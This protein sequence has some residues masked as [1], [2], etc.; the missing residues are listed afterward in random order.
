MWRNI[1][2]NIHPGI[3]ATLIY[4]TSK[5]L[6]LFITSSFKSDICFLQQCFKTCL[7]KTHLLTSGSHCMNFGELQ[8]QISGWELQKHDLRKI[9]ASRINKWPAQR[10]LTEFVKIK[11]PREQEKLKPLHWN[12]PRSFL[13][14]LF[15][16][17]VFS[18][19]RSYIFSPFN[20]LKLSHKIWKAL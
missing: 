18:P 8:P 13:V 6:H 2:L 4:W 1:D 5:E 19:P 12:N 15:N 16:H 14:N 20:Q 7:L 17:L 9:S 11:T 10:K 3:S